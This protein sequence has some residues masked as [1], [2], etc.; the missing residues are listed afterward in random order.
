[1]NAGSRRLFVALIA[2]LA[3]AV[4]APS[5]SANTEDIIATLRCPP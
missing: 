3:T 1:M 2:V 5:A 4:L